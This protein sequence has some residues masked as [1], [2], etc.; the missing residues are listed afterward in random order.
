MTRTR[1][2]YMR[3][4]FADGKNLKDVYCNAKF[5]VDQLQELR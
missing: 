3:F 2:L 1:T 4:D 5:Y